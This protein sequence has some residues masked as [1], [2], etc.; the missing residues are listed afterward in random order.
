MCNLNIKSVRFIL[1]AFAVQ[2]WERGGG[3]PGDG[4]EDLSE[5]SRRQVC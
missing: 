4:K 1:I 3:I 5:H 2:R